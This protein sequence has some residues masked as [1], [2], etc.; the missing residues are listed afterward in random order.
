VI[1]AL[2]APTVALAEATIYGQAHV[3]MDWFD[4]TGDEDTKYKGWRLN[5]GGMG[6]GNPRGSRMGIKGSEDLGR[7]LKAIY[8][9]EFNIPLKDAEEFGITD[10]NRMDLRM[11]N[12]YA[13]LKGAFGTVLMGRHDTPFKLSTSK[14][15]LFNDTMADHQGTLGFD[16]LRIDSTIVYMTPRIQGFQFAAALIPGAASTLPGI[17]LEETS[18][19]ADGLAEGYSLAATYANGPWYF[20]VVHE[21][22]G[23]NFEGTLEDDPADFEKW[24]VGLGI[25]DLAGFYMSTLYEEQRAI[26]ALEKQY[27]KNNDADMWQVQVGYALGNNMIKAMYGQKDHNLETTR[28][29]NLTDLTSWAFGFDHKLSPRTKAYAL[30]THVDGDLNESD[31]KGTSLGMIHSF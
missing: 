12:S 6:K 21:F 13:G 28:Y 16:D 24:R 3:T 14:L 31:W 25:R 8:Q 17:F 11:R 7:G 30:Y 5:R 23:E 19:E 26:N 10:I 29:Y 22:M 15:D 27:G 20:G 2:A 18:L 9:I 4:I 1:A